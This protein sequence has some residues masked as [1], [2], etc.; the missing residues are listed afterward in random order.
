[1]IVCSCRVLSEK[2][3]NSHEEMINRLLETDAQC[4]VC[5]EEFKLVEES[6]PTKGETE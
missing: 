3:F 1:M 6:A 5:C 4:G 2:D